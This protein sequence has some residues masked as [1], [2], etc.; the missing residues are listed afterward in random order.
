[1]A[2][3]ACGLQRLFLQ[4]ENF[5]TCTVDHGALQTIKQYRTSVYG[6]RKGGGLAGCVTVTY[7]GGGKEVSP[8]A[9][10]KRERNESNTVCSLLKK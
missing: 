2:G 10:R 1:M 6:G 7:M 5:H 4:H 8:L 3:T 9:G